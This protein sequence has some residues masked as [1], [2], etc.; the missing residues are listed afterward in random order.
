MEGLTKKELANIA[1]YTYRRLYDIDKALPNES[2]LFVERDDGKYDLPTFVQRWVAYNLSA[3]SD[4][5]VDLDTVK[6]RH[7]EVKLQ[8]T[9]L[10]VEQMRGELVAVQDV[11]KLWG[12]IAN[13]IMQAMIHLPS[14]LAPM[15]QGLQSIEAISGIID[16]EIR[17]V[18]IALAD[19]PVPEYAAKDMT[20]PDGAEQT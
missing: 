19:T 16:A 10:E 17:R 1:G 14:T 7:E 6:A 3:N 4:A 5:P 2:K 13:S 12:T 18:L 9:Q 8:K 20:E 11:R 15:V